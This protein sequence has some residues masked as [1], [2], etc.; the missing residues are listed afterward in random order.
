MVAFD[1]IS[2]AEKAQILGAGMQ[3]SCQVQVMSELRGKSYKTCVKNNEN[4]CL[5]SRFKYSVFVK[6]L[7]GTVDILCSLEVKQAH[8]GSTPGKHL[9]PLPFSSPHFLLSISFWEPLHFAVWVINKFICLLSYYSVK[10][11]LI[12]EFA[13][14]TGNTMHKKCSNVHTKNI[15]VLTQITK[16][17]SSHDKISMGTAEYTQAVFIWLCMLT[18]ASKAHCHSAF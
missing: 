5:G 7:A 16:T 4:Y 10:R 18:F 12:A 9:L 13:K 6:N 11:Q 3:N 8:R 15:Y 17:R 2:G 1:E 14:C